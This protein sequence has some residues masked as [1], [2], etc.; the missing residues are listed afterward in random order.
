MKRISFSLSMTPFALAQD[1]SSPSGDKPAIIQDL[2]VVVQK[3]L[4]I[5]VRFAGIAV[6]IMLLVGGF[7]YLTAG[8]DP[9]KG[10]GNRASTE[11]NSANPQHLSFRESPDAASTYGDS[12]RNAGKRFP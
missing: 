6:F 5:V 4:N 11:R 2:V 7:Q 3:I 8:G 12:A 10:T 9:K 1:W